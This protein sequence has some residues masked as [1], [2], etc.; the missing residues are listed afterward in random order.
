MSSG[1]EPAAFARRV[2]LALVGLTPQVV[3]ET[4]WALAAR[5]R[6]AFVPTEIVIVTTA[7]GRERAELTLL[8]PEGGQLRRLAEDL[9]LPQLAGAFGPEGMHVARGA[10]GRLLGD[11]RTPEDNLAV[12]DLLTRL[13]AAITADADAALH[14][15][16]AGGR[17]SMSFFAGYALSLFARPQDRLS[18]V[19]VEPRFE[20]HPQFF[21]PPCRPVV[22]LVPPDGRPMRTD[23]S[24][25]MLAEIPFVRLREGLPEGLLDGRGGFA[26]AVAA[27]QAGIGEPELLLDIRARRAT[28]GGTELPLPPLQLAFLLVMA[29][30]RARDDGA[31]GWR[32]LPP[33]E[34]QDAYGEL[35]GWNA[36]QGERLAQSLA[37]GV[38]REWF[39]ERKARHDKLVRHTLG[40]RAAPYLLEPVGRRPLTRFRLALPPWCI[41]ITESGAAH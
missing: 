35:F 18:H 24:C 13:M 30:R 26:E 5:R 3:T 33:R 10:D 22:L 9:G 32:E 20:G 21:F 4:L 25:V 15:S 6:P 27:A 34:I 28:A 36:P 39:Q 8:E 12:A 23:A 37:G 14:V 29:R 38:G 40:R 31:A 11:I 17:K 16:I 41:R 2:L 1:I 19:L 7:E